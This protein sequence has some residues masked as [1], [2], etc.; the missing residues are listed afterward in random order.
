M[1]T[2]LAPV[3]LPSLQ[4]AFYRCSSSS[5]SVVVAD[6]CRGVD[7]GDDNHEHNDDYDNGGGRRRRSRTCRRCATVELC[8][9]SVCTVG[10][11]RES[12]LLVALPTILV[13]RLHS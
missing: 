1:T 6:S 4:V 2:R 8:V 13:T 12:P 11:V 9:W 7:D 3:L 5:P 10:I